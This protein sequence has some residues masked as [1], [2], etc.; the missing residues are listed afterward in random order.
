MMF[1]YQWRK[2]T[3]PIRQLPNFMIMG[4]QKG[5]TTFLFHHLCQHPD[6]CEPKEK[7][8][9]FFNQRAHEPIENYKHLFPSKIDKIL[10]PN[11][12]AGEATP[13]YMIYPQVPALVHKHNPDTKIIVLLKNPIE[14]AF[15][16]YKHNVSMKREWYS[17]EDALKHEEVRTNLEYI[18]IFTSRKDA[19]KNYSNFSYKR[20][21]IYAEQLGW[22]FRH[23]DRNQVLVVQSEELFAKP[24]ETIKT[25]TDFLGTTPLSLSEYPAKHVSTLNMAI[26]P[27]TRDYLR[28]FYQDHNQ[29]LFKMIGTTYDWN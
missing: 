8:I 13:C 2:F 11:L 17:F 4:T 18:D 25:V 26:N 15:S 1:D 16:N 12:I 28:E 27:D 19:I 29:S 14:R 10:N 24:K 6:I 7:E 20:K 21:G 5:G 22:I 23:F 3:R 9:H